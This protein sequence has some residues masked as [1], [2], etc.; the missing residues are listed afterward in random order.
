[1]IEVRDKIIGDHLR[2]ILEFLNALYLRVDEPV[3]PE[4]GI[5]LRISLGGKSILD[6][7]QQLRYNCRTFLNAIESRVFEDMRDAQGF[8][9]G[10]PVTLRLRV[11]QSQPAPVFAL[12]NVVHIVP[13]ILAVERGHVV[14]D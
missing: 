2:V 6:Q 13:H 12:I 14:A 11:R 5:P 7:S 1:M 8:H 4:D 9:E 3:L 10:P